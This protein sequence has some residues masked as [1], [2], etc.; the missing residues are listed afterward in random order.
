MKRLS[1]DKRF[2][3]MDLNIIYLFTKN[4]KIGPETLILLNEDYYNLNSQWVGREENYFKGN[5]AKFNLLLT[6]NL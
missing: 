5:G 1:T 2:N 6:F 4:P 3:G